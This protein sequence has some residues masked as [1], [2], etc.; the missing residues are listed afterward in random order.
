MGKEKKNILH[1]SLSP[2][3]EGRELYVVRLSEF[4]EKDGFESYCLTKPNSFI[5][6]K[7]KEIILKISASTPKKLFLSKALDSFERSLK[8]TIFK[9]SLFID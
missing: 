6:K 7:L 5:E 3:A 9:L 2:S 1:I 8:N 4:F